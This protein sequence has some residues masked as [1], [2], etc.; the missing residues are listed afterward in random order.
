[1]D[2]YILR[3]GKSSAVEDQLILMLPSIN[4]ATYIRAPAVA[5]VELLKQ[6]GIRT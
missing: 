2:H 5:Y 6:E 4:I 3:A 1:M